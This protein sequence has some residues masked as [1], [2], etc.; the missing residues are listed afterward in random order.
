MLRELLRQEGYIVLDFSDAAEA[1]R[2]LKLGPAPD[3]IVL[4][5]RMPG[6][7]GWHFRIEQKKDPCLVST[8]VIALSA[9]GSSQA[10]AID[11]NAFLEK[12]PSPVELLDSVRRVLDHQAV[13]QKRAS[14]MVLE[15]MA[16]LGTLAAG[17]A[18]EINNPLAYV[19]ANMGLV[20]EELRRLTDPSMTADTRQ[21]V[22]DEIDGML[23]E[24][25]DGAGRIEKIVRDLRVVSHVEDP[26]PLTM[27]N[28]ND[29]LESTLSVAASAINPR[30]RVVRALGTPPLVL[31]NQ[32]RLGQVFLNLLVN[33]AQAIP[34]GA[35]NGQIK[36]TTK[37]G[38]SGEALIFISDNGVGIRPEIRARIFVPFFTTKPTGDGSGLG[39][40]VCHGTVTSM[41]GTIAVE[42]QPGFGSTFEVSLPGAA[43]EGRSGAVRE[44]SPRAVS[45]RIL[46]VDDEPAIGRVLARILR[47]HHEISVVDSGERGLELALTQPF[48]IV[49]CD[50]LM[51]K[52][53]GADLY[54]HLEA[55]GG[56]REKRIV[57]MT[58]GA[59]TPRDREFVA[60]VESVV[61]E[62]PIG[63]DDLYRAI[64]ETLQRVEAISP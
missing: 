49:L 60:R 27:V 58:G 41:G 7:D 3:L 23:N 26:P 51:A 62:K 29:L 11:A 59:F 38:D 61:L 17:I 12:P 30:A 53:T 28:I 15:R 13:E 32:A 21:A 45:L 19:I 64:R 10:R 57:F 20:R 25:L 2:T 8:P 35:K 44:T 54:A 48:D 36:I 6:M 5:L 55:A 50:L 16:A 4:D 56:G 22:A 9:D 47:A 34:E 31:G 33:A 37:T 43:A 14:L 1:L 42:S 63:R 18:H 52:V 40:S 46:I 39:L 24:A